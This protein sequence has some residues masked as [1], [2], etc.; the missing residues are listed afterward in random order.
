MIGK[1]IRGFTYAL[2]GIAFTFRNHF[3]M[4][5]HVFIMLFVVAAAFI[6]K[7]TLT[8]WCIILLCMGSVVGAELVNTSIEITVDIH[9]PQQNEKAGHAKDVAAAS[10]LLV[11]FISAIIGLIIFIPKILRYF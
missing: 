6:F 9:S 10:V 11:S 3:N 5:V 8:E 7:L 2:S 1:F 4:R